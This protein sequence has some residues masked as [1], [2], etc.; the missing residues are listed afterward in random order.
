MTS[1]PPAELAGR[2]ALVTAAVG[3]L[4]RVL[5][6]GLAEAGLHV[7][8][9]TLTGAREEEFQANSILNECWSLGRR[10][11]AHALD[12]AD[13]GAVESMLDAVEAE[14]GPLSVLVNGAFAVPTVAAVDADVPDWER[15][16]RLGATAAYVPTLAAGRRMLARGQGRIVSVVSVLHDRGAPGG[17]LIGAAS[18]AVAALTRSLGVEWARSGVTVNALAAGLIEGL[19]GPHADAQARAAIERYI[20]SRRIGRPEDLVGALI[21][22]VSDAAAYVNAEVLA[23]D[24]GLA[25]HA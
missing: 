9:T 5:A 16:L 7:S 15:A 1:W 22:L 18:G 8:V 24:G 4:G 13:P 25:V 14:A 20:P 3:P 23:V 21:Y 2:S 6:V 12:L 17:S 10:G 19:P 11:G